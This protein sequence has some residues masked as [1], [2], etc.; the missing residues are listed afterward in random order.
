MNNSLTIKFQLHYFRYNL[1]KQNQVNHNIHTEIL[2]CNKFKSIITL[3][4]Q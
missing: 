3:L 1:L 4:D 2:C